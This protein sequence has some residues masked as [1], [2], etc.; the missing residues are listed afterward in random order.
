VSPQVYLGIF[1][2]IG[3]SKAEMPT[4]GNADKVMQR[5]GKAVNLW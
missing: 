5:S 4:L 3:L 2:M 1:G